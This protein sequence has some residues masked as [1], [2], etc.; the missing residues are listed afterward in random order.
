MATVVKYNGITIYNGEVEHLEEYKDK[1]RE[2][3]YGRT[4]T[5]RQRLSATDLRH[6]TRGIAYE[7]I[8]HDE[9]MTTRQ[10]VRDGKTVD[11]A[12]IDG[13]EKLIQTMETAIEK[14]NPTITTEL[15]D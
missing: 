13:A 8:S 4:G 15:F 1:T 10:E 3:Y 7:G 12:T 11:A 2:I 5:E 14:R 6:G 9:L